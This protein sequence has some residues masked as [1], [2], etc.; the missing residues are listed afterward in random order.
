MPEGEIRAITANLVQAMRFFG[1][2]RA[3]GEVR[4]CPGICLISCGLNYAAFNAA[5][6]WEP[7]QAYDP[8]ALSANIHLSQQHFEQRRLRWTYWLCDDFLERRLQRESQNIFHRHGLSPLTDA[9]GM[10]ADRLLAPSRPLPHV[11]VKRVADQPTRL[12]FGHITSIAFEIPFA[13]CHEIYGADRAWAGNFQGYVGYAGGE[14]VAT[15]AIVTS[16]D[17]IGVY[18]V[19][20][21]PHHRKRGYAESLMRQVISKAQDETGLERTVLQ[22]TRSGLSLYERMGYRKVTRFTVYIC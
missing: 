20:T 11:E 17:A 2:A 4:E 14:P 1:S 21:L 6:L 19:A 18:S 5:L 16:H 12:A 9:P 7:L 8:R 22:S 15:A 13:V 10:C 3:A